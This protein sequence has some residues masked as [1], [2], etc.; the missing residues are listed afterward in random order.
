MKVEPFLL[1]VSLAVMVSQRLVGRLCSSCRKAD[2]APPPVQ[3][4]ISDAL[5]A[6]PSELTSQF[7]EP[8]RIY[9]APGC[10]NCKGRGIAGRIALYEA[11][12]M[13]PALQEIITS[14]STLQRIFKEAR[15]QGMV[16]LREDGV[17]KALAGEVL[18]E[19]VIRETEE[20]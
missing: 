17:L 1:P 20:F 8:Y 7:R 6:L 14:G 9:H 18:I 10:P 12:E 3:K 16:T 11:F 2:V 19:E 13:S 15:N 4:I 5:R